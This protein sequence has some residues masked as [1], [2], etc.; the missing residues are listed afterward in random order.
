MNN[1][2]LKGIVE[3]FAKNK[4]MIG[5]F[6]TFYQIFCNY[7]IL[8]QKYYDINW[9]FPYESYL[10]YEL[11]KN[12]DF[13]FENEKSMAIDG[14]FAIHNKQVIHLNLE[15]DD[16]NDCFNKIDKGVFEIV[17]IQTKS[18]KID[19]DDIST[20]SDCLN[21]NFASQ[22]SWER[23]VNFRKRCE[24]LIMER[25]N[26]K[27]KFSIYY[28]AGNQIDSSIFT[29]STF[30]VRENALKD[31]MKKYF[32]IREDENIEIK[33]LSDEDVYT[34]YEE[35]SLKLNII[36][37]TMNL[38]EMTKEIECGVFG[39][40]R[41]GA[42]SF[43]ELMK[44][45]Y[46]TESQKP[47]DLYGYN[48]RSEIENS[49]INDSII[50]SISTNGEKFLLLNN[51]ITIVVDN[52]E[53][54]GDS[55]I[56]LENIRIVNG[57][58]TSHSILKSCIGNTNNNNIKVPI[59][60][61]QKYNNE[62]ILGDITYSSNNQNAVSKDNLLS[63]HPKM[64]QLEKMYKD[65]ELTNT[66]KFNSVYF[67]RRQ[68]QF[69]NQPI[70]YIDMLAQAK[71]YISLWNRK[72]HFSAMYKDV[73]LSE[74]SDNMESDPNFLN[75]SLICGILWANIH[76]KILSNFENARYQIF[77]SMVLDEL[78]KELDIKCILNLSAVDFNE[79]CSY[80]NSDWLSKINLNFEENINLAIET[81]TKNSNRFPITTKTGRVHYKEFY[82]VDALK[83]IYEDYKNKVT[84]VI[85]Q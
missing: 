78:E 55:G 54:K 23:F 43:G 52:Q 25:P 9:E 41:F 7:L 37:K 18:G 17:L 67:E 22:K 68:G 50:K 24:K 73:C 1:P 12:I 46:N 53:R 44:I 16:L 45:I 2:R 32:W 35:Q 69:N 77:T 84:N 47:N 81:I 8:K 27:L 51:G 21:T 39:K 58:Q 4:K 80:L 79:K 38:E 40:I 15:D 72:P 74:Y 71:A 60:I 49:P 61:I 34:L 20:L 48:V 19:P 6:P 65:F 62:E 70:E 82:K 29:N 14:C 10:D 26:L 36:T 76:N 11:L 59:K 30:T 33:Y 75:K 66:T 57:C 56:Y 3:R 63:I 64:F 83:I 28:V 42:I 31:S 5:D 85:N 13:D